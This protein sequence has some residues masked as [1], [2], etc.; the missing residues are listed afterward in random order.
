M[1]TLL[2]KVRLY[3]DLFN[4]HQ[5]SSHRFAQHDFDIYWNMSRKAELYI[6]KVE[7]KRIL[8]VGCGQRY[9]LTL[10]FHNTRNMVTGCDLSHIT[11]AWKTLKYEGLA[12]ILK[13]IIRKLFFDWQYYACLEY[14]SGLKLNDKN[15]DIRYLDAGNLP[16][17]DKTFDLVVSNAVFEHIAD[18]PKAVAEICRIL[19]PNAITY[20]NIHLFCS[21]S[22][23]HS[24]DWS[25]PDKNL[26]R[27][28]PP[29]DHLRKN[30]F[31]AHVYLNK[32]RERDYLSAFQRNFNILEW[33]TTKWE[34]EK[35]LTPQIERELSD[36]S[37]EELLKREI[38]VVAKKR[39]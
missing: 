13:T 3:R 10:L 18:V 27:S 4:Y 16:F 29:W 15:L 2:K 1:R 5:G 23:G 28:V 17:A 11:S 8:D 31:P 20:N 24:F 22:G 39:S 33:I 7:N 21:L 35:F 12:R 6:G 32:L 36:Y 19:K 14:I 38:T 25:Y 9:P 26:P 30:L 37:R 34:G